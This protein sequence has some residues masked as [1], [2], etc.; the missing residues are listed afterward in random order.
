MPFPMVLAWIETQTAVPK[1]RTRITDS[2]FSPQFGLIYE[3]NF[4][5]IGW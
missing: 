4:L 5:I 1:I 3:K 2:I